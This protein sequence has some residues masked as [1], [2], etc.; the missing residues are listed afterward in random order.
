MGFPFIILTSIGLCYLDE[1]PVFLLYKK[2]FEECK[3]VLKRITKINKRPEF[4]FNLLEEMHEVNERYVSALDITEPNRKITEMRESGF[5]S[6]PK[7]GKDM[8]KVSVIVKDKEISKIKVFIKNYKLFILWGVYYFAYF[9]LPL[10]IQS[11]KIY[12]LNFTF[13]GI[14]ELAGIYIASRIISKMDNMKI[15]QYSMVICTLFSCLHNFISTSFSFLLVTKFFLTIFFAVL[16][17]HTLET[18]S[19]KNRSKIFGYCF[20]FG[21]LFAISMPLVFGQLSAFQLS[22]VSVLVIMFFIS[23]LFLIKM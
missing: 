20:M 4:K 17:I 19:V 6:M 13:L 1:T 3:E 14:I 18:F 23:T 15:M 7:E 22:P 12:I 16:Q 2:R 5:F 11:E 10:L 8:N 21:R 9:G